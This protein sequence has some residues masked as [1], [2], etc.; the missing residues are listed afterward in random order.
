MKK[1]VLT[2]C[3]IPFLTIPAF[4]GSPVVVDK[5]I[6][7]AQG[8]DIRFGGVGIEVGERDPVSGPRLAP[9]PPGPGRGCDRQAALSRSRLGP[10]IVSVA[11]PS[12][13]L[14]SLKWNRRVD[15]VSRP[16]WA[17]QA[18]RPRRHPAF[19]ASSIETLGAASPGRQLVPAGDGLEI[20]RTLPHETLR[21]RRA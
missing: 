6:V 4:A 17:C 3:V 19:H 20:V 13:S 7:V 2:L 21:R 9:V 18:S 8:A 14:A 15:A 5:P 1:T 12:T 11:N 16:P 10:T